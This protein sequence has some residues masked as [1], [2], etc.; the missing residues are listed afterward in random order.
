M[1][2]AKPKRTKKTNEDEEENNHEHPA[3]A[4]C[5]GGKGTDK[6]FMVNPNYCAKY[7]VSK[8]K[9]RVI[10]S[11]AINGNRIGEL[12]DCTKTDNEN[13]LLMKQHGLDISLV[14]L[15]RW[16]KQNGITKYKKNVS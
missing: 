8:K 10:A 6:Q 15:K 5:N 11:K 14:T 13:L 4:C 9:A 3:C 1:A 16:R 7:G 12:Y 2:S